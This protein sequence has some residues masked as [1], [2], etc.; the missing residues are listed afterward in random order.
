M[1]EHT[2]KRRIDK[3]IISLSFTGPATNR[4]NAIRALNDLGFVETSDTVTW[5]EVFPEYE[6]HEIPGVIIAGARGREGL[7][8]KE[9]SQITGIPQGNIS[10][11]E[12]GKRK[13]GVTIAKKLGK[14]LNVSYKVFL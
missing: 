10:D 12:R 1:L 11:M 13:I 8:Q 14:A 5:E 9:L 2:K 4:D 7:T 3:E 6:E